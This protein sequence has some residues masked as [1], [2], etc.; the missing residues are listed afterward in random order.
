[1]WDWRSKALAMATHSHTRVFTAQ[2]H[3]N[4]GFGVHA[5]SMAQQ[6]GSAEECMPLAPAP[7]STLHSGNCFVLSFSR[8]MANKARNVA[9]SRYYYVMVGGKVPRD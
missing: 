3:V 1:M 2:E 8:R 9:R 6:S 5:F 7:M 4:K